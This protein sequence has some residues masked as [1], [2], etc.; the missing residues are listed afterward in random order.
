MLLLSINILLILFAESDFNACASFLSSNYIFRFRLWRHFMVNTRFFYAQ[1]SH[2]KQPY[3]ELLKKVWKFNFSR[4]CKLSLKK[5]FYCW[6]EFYCFFSLIS[7][8]YY[9]EFRV[10]QEI[11]Q[12]TFLRRK[13]TTVYVYL[14]TFWALPARHFS[15]LPPSWVF[16]E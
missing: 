11:I 7:F 13:L 10:N 14:N 16:N 15:H 1:Y 5:I 4:I 2:F 12:R 3:L 8:S 6:V 9:N